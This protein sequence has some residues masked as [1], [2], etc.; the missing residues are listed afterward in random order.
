MEPPQKEKATRQLQ[1]FIKRSC[2][3]GAA[4]KFKAQCEEANSLIQ[5]LG[6]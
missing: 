6:Q 4:A 2:R 1:S 3:S 5:K